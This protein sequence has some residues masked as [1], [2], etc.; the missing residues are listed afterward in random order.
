M[1]ALLAAALLS[2]SWEFAYHSR[3][4][5]P[6]AVMAQFL[7]LSLLCLVAGEISGTLSW[8]YLGAVAMGLAG[9]T[10]YTA[11]FLLAFFVPGAGLWVWRINGAGRLRG[12]NSRGSWTP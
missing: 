10:K 2:C 7:W 11:A 8:F 4:I 1:E 3:W 9:G 6:D 12:N 5:A